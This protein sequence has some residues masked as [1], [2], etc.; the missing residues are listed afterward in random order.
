MNL[1]LLEPITLDNIHTLK[2]GDWIWDNAMIKRRVH[3]R[4]LGGEYITE[5]TGFRQIH[6]LDLDTFG[7][8][9]L[10]PF[11]LSNVYSATAASWVYFK[12]GQFWK[13]REE[14]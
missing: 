8:H 1:E 5:P 14:V 13:F 6:V 4:S 9:S 12:D 3:K 10:Q 7:V 11:M 2:P